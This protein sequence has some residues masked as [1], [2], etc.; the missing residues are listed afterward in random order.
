MLYDYKWINLKLW[1]LILRNIM[2]RFSCKCLNNRDF[3][4]KLMSNMYQ[5][6]VFERAEIIKEYGIIYDFLGLNHVLT[7]KIKKELSET[8]CAINF[9]YH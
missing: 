8:C 9:R 2:K 7:V 5:S 3:R 1:N 6:G 4:K